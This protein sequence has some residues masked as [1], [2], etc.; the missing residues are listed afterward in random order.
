[1]KTVDDIELVIDREFAAVNRA[2]SQ[3]VDEDLKRSV[4]R[5]GRFRE[6]IKYWMDGDRPLVVDGHRRMGVWKSLPDDTKISPPRAE[7]MKFSS[8]LA[9]VAWIH[10]ES[11]SRRNLTAQEYSLQR[12]RFVNVL[13]DLL[14]SDVDAAEWDVF[15]QSVQKPPSA[16]RKPRGSRPKATGGRPKSHTRAAVAAVAAQAG[17]STKTVERDV[18]YAQAIDAIGLVNPKAKADLE[19]GTLTIPRGTVVEIGSLDGRGIGKALGNIRAGRAWDAGIGEKV[20]NPLEIP[21]EQDVLKETTA[22]LDRLDAII[23]D[24]PED[25]RERV[26]VRLRKL[27]YKLDPVTRNGQFVKPTV[28][29]VGAYCEER[30]NGIDAEEFIDFYE[31]KGWVVGKVKMKDWRASVRTWEKE[32][33]KRNGRSTK[34]IND[35]AFDEV[36]RGRR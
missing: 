34:G 6:S 31:S 22:M 27:A 28:A 23:D 13:A 30:N 9:V 24:V 1:M 2:T 33:K 12:G 8:R 32:H 7:E 10:L 19:R 3:K 25:D 5:D 21:Q 18:A 4:L 29:E 16:P 35:A 20:Q 36:F 26:A 11:I 17:V 15:R 14:A